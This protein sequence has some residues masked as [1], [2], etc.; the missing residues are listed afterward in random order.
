MLNN[1]DYVKF[2][3]KQF[4]IPAILAATVL[5]AGIFAFMPIEQATTVHT[6]IQGTQN[7]LVRVASPICTIVDAEADGDCNISVNIT[8]GTP[9][10]FRSIEIQA[11]E[12]ADAGDDN[13]NY[14]QV[15]VTNGPQ[16]L[17]NPAANT[18]DLK[19]TTAGNDG[20]TP[21]VG[22]GAGTITSTLTVTNEDGGDAE[23]I[24]V[25]MTFEI[26]GS[27]TAPVITLIP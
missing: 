4:A 16:N 5:I 14:A 7:Q 3:V 24:Q 17:V 21:F 10:I 6:T 22:G 23:T 20:G 18:N 2:N 25:W 26:A 9:A 19:I 13:F 12:G 11:F 1:T 15:N 27:A 8:A